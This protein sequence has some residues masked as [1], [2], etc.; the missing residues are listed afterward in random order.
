MPSAPPTRMSLPRQAVEHVSSGK[1]Q[2]QIVRAGWCRVSGH[3][4]VRRADDDVERAAVSELHLLDVA[5]PVG[6]VERVL[7]GVGHDDL[8]VGGCREGIFAASALE[9]GGVDVA[10]GRSVLISRTICS[11]PGLILPSNIQALSGLVTSV[12]PVATSAL[13]VE[14]E[15]D[16]AGHALDLLGRTVDELKRSFGPVGPFSLKP[17]MM[18]MRTFSHLSP[19]MMSSPALPWI[20]RCRRRRG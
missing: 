16:Q 9:L 1:A 19:S 8:A 13:C 3:V 5:Q 20:S 7:D 2:D 14:P 6:A 18:P 11:W 12:P 15:R 17:D 4:V 10:S